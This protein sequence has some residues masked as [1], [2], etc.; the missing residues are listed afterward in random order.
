ME[1]E[2]EQ[3]AQ[4]RRWYFTPDGT[5]FMSVTTVLGEL[6]EDTTGLDRWKAKHDGT[7][8][9]AHHEHIFWFSQIRGTLCH[10]QALVAF[11][12]H[13]DA[14]ELWGDEE[15]EAITLAVNGP[16]DGTFE[17][18]SHD[19]EDIVYSLLR[20]QDVVTGRDEFEH[21]FAETTRIV[22]VLRDN[23]DYFV[24]AFETVCETLG[25]TDDSVITVEKFMLNDEHGYGGQCDLV[26]EDPEGN[27]V[28]ADLKTSSGLRQKHRLQ[29][30]AY[31]KAVEQ[32][33]DIDVEEVDRVEVIRIHPGSESWQVHTNEVPAHVED[34]E[35]VTDD[36]WFT[37]KW[38]D[39]DYDSIEDMWE[40]FKALTVEAHAHADE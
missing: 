22:D 28:V 25:I 38:G 7:G 31:A 9:N 4:G 15:S 6:D 14:A 37:D 29:S 20:Y 27:T 21:L 12:D 23:V 3:D 2:R 17:D 5:R 18:A 36:H 34:E 13:H 19:S 8:D 26:Y 10:Y 11:E 40:T 32:A 16:D 39:F 24:D 33:D 1:I 35:S 30:V